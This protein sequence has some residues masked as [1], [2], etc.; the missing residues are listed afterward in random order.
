MSKDILDKLALKNKE[1][2]TDKDFIV[3]PVL[4]M[5]H[6]IE[7]LKI[8]DDFSNGEQVNDEYAFRRTNIYIP[9]EETVDNDENITIN[10]EDKSK[11]DL[12]SYMLDE[13]Q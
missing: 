2:L 13:T 5:S 10:E 8:N 6:N 4:G 11:A 9:L 1:N 12:S 3:N 7:T